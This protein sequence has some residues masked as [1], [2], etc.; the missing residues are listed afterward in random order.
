MLRGL[1]I[2]RHVSDPL[3]RNLLKILDGISIDL[4]V[5]FQP[6]DEGNDG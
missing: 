6:E 2:Y 4:V 5:I 3:N 1:Q